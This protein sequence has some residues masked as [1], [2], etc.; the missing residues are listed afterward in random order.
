MLQ[1]NIKAIETLSDSRLKLT[2][3]TGETRVFDVSPYIKGEWYGKLRD[4]LYFQKITIAHGGWGIEWPDGQ[5]IAPHELYDL[6]VPYKEES[7]I[8]WSS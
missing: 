8:A 3:E 4:D 5:D 7:S 6:S 1:P 2:Y